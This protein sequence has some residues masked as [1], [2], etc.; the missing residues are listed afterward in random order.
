[1]YHFNQKLS[2][3]EHVISDNTHVC[4]SCFD[5]FEY[6][7]VQRGHSGL[8]MVPVFFAGIFTWLVI[9]YGLSMLF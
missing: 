3:A 6:E 5:T 2:A 8:W 7:T 1:M 9:F 4:K